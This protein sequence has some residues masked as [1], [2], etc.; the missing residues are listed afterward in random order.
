MPCGVGLGEQ[1]R[2]VRAMT[3]L[4]LSASIMC[5]SLVRMEEEIRS[6]E[7][8]G[9]DSIHIDVMDGHFVP[10]LTFGVDMVAAIRLVTALPLH[11]HLMVSDPGLMV[12][13]LARA[14]ADV[15][16]FHLEAERYP[17][18]LIERISALQMSPGIALNPA[19]PV[20]TV[21]GMLAPYLLVMTVEPGFAGQRWLAQSAERVRRAREVVR[22]DTVIGVDGNV[23]QENACIARSAGASLFVCGTSVLF[24]PGQ[25]YETALFE[26]R[27]ALGT[28]S[29]AGVRSRG[30][31]DT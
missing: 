2:R 3:G 20:D 31:D 13:P 25:K 1:V 23:S 18:R 28:Q 27:E 8:A 24:G 16:I 29:P 19:T 12:E 17:Y 26:L 10:N 6:L 7:S 4:D 11:V 22:E 21:S 5:A 30:P 15:C 14:G 9:I